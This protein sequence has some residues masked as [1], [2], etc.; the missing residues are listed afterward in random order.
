VLLVSAW[1]LA[2][3]LPTLAMTTETADSPAPTD[4]QCALIEAHDT[5]G[6]GWWSSASLE[7]DPAP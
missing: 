4:S 1:A 3:S 2:L 7:I 6:I 5:A